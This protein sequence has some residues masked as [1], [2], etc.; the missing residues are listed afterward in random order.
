MMSVR[1]EHDD[2]RFKRFMAL[3]DEGFK[4]FGTLASV[5]FIP[6][7]RYLP[8]L[9]ETRQKLAEVSIRVFSPEPF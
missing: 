6:M 1:F 4:L 8:G 3:I 2:T 5:N 9:L 7:M